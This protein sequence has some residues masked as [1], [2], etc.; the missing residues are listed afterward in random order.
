FTDIFK[1]FVQNSSEVIALDINCTFSCKHQEDGKCN[2]E[3]THASGYANSVCPYFVP[4][5]KKEK[6]KDE[7]L[8]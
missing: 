1:E 4:R 8:H 2:N 6:K 7:Q 3:D 5:D